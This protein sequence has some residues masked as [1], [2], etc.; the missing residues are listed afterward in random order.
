MGYPPASRGPVARVQTPPKAGPPKS[1]PL[2][3]ERER[4]AFGFAAWATGRPGR[5]APSGAQRPPQGGPSTDGIPPASQGSD[6][7]AKP[8][9]GRS[10]EESTTRIRS[11]ERSAFGFAAWA[12]GRPGRRAPSGAQRPPQGGPSTDGIPPASQGSDSSTKPGH[13][14]SAE[15]STTRI[16]SRER[17]AFGFAA[18][19][20][21]RPGRRAPSGAQ[22]PPQGGPSTDGIPPASQGSDSSA[23]PGHD[24]SAEESTTR[25]RSRERSA[26]GFAAWATGRPGRRAPSGAQRPPQGGPS[27]D[28]IPPASRGPVGQA[29]SPNAD[30]L[31]DSLL[32]RIRGHPTTRTER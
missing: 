11:R 20:T 32:R 5:R 14:R 30:R 13:D 24:R 18:W 4:S 28:G 25:I 1:R 3:S 29:A 26:F 22:R 16:R 10:A 9:H 21:G 23:K 15:E 8:G 7:S 31:Y 19:A 12:T 17:S 2:E 6:S 27:T